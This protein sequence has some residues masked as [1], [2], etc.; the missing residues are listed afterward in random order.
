MSFHVRRKDKEIADTEVLKRILKSA[1]YVTIAMCMDNQP[2][3]VSL[4]H[5][6][7]E[8]H[9]CIYFHCA[10]EG[11]KL[12][13][14]EANNVVW[15][16]AV[17]DY[18]YAEGECEHIYASV[19]FLG[20]VTFLTDLGE[21]RSAVECMI[22]QLDKNPEPLLARLSNERLEKAAIGKI[23]IA[24]MSGKKSKQVTL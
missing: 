22:R 9:N 14:L 23:A 17:L 24:Y 13:Y 3:L 21:K 8:K 19:H 5:G 12:V 11:K 20:K 4:S 10:L 18:G 2:Y 6:Y 7:D 16:Q 1:K 15:G